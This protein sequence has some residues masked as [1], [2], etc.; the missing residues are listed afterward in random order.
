MQRRV[1]IVNEPHERLDHLAE[2]VAELGH[3]P[4]VCWV[5]ADGVSAL[6]GREHPDVALIGPGAGPEQALAVITEMAQD[7]ACPVIALID[8]SDPAFIRQAARR[9][10]FAFVLRDDPGELA[11]AM[12]VALQRFAEYHSLR[13]A[14]DRR[15]VIEQAKGILMAHHG[16]DSDAAFAMLR[17]HSQRSGQKLID[18]AHGMVVSHQLLGP[19]AAIS[20][21]SGEG[22]LSN[23]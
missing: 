21:G 3:D 1:L 23:T 8:A 20:G 4:I 22:I 13:G 15:A 10:V 14:F 7:G 17:E 11:G 9:G 12:E 2:A 16:V 18:V 5:E 19:P 6:L